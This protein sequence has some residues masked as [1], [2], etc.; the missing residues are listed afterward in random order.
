MVSAGIAK[1]ARL[2]RAASNEWKEGEKARWETSFDAHVTFL[3]E[4]ATEQARQQAKTHE[5]AK[6]RAMEMEMDPVSDL[7]V[8]GVKGD[9]KSVV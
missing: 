7:S 8:P 5:A 9:R 3:R 6:M 2:T 4:K 1:G